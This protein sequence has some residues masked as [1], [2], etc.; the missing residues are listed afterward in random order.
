MSKYFCAFCQKLQEESDKKQEELNAFLKA[1]EDQVG[2]SFQV[3]ISEYITF[4][5]SKIL[6]AHEYNN[7]E[8]KDGGSSRKRSWGDW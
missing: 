1:E 2:P 7:L 8:E 3:F 5:S 6:F 4:A